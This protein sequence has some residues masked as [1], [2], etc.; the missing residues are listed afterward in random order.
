MMK[1]QQRLWAIILVAIVLSFGATHGY[2][3]KTEPDVEFVPTPTKVV[4]EMLKI[5]NVTKED[6]VYDL[7]CGDGRI[8]I[9]AA[10]LYGARGVGVDIDPFRIRESNENAAKAGVADRVKFFQGDLFQTDLSEASVVAL[11]LLPELNVRLR[12]KL[13][14]ELKPGTRIVSH[15]FHMGDWK[16]DYSGLVKNVS[17]QYF[18][19]MGHER[20]AQFYYWVI[21]AHAAGLWRLG[22]ETPTSQRSFTLRLEQTF[23]EIKGS[24]ID[25][26]QEA[27]I[28]DARLMGD[29]ISFTMKNGMDKRPVIMHFTGRISGDTMK[30]SAVVQ[31][32]SLTRKHDWTARRVNSF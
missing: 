28:I 3:Q 1:I 32:G 23:Q 24:V 2:G 19:I 7:G 15:D 30:G 14:R 20:D 10:K 16:P 9:T 21:P 13:F 6:V 4:L 26:G 22:V 12:P 27:A 17:Y 31:E 18:E 5:A 8:V 11:Y 25:R 29:Q